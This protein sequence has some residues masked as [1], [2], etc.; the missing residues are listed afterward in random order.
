[1]TKK[2]AVLCLLKSV[3]LAYVLTG[4]LILAGGWISYKMD[5]S[6]K[7]LNLMVIFIYI[8]V[9]MF[10]GIYM[11]RKLQNKRY[12]WGML[13]GLSYAAILIIISIVVPGGTSGID[14]D[15][16]CAILLCMAGGSLGGIVS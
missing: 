2:S 11:G 9:N 6:D 16:I 12:I 15:G 13:A 8:C 5:L 7:I 14:L 4:L 10:S 3:L 1:M